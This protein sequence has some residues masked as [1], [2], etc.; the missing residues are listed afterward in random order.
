VTLLGRSWRPPLRRVTRGRCIFPP[1]NFLEGLSAGSLK[2]FG[3]Q[4]WEVGLVWALSLK[5]P[6]EET[7]TLGDLVKAAATYPGRSPVRLGLLVE[8]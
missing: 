3:G 7:S 8:Y 6:H 5:C 1:C 4:M 2:G